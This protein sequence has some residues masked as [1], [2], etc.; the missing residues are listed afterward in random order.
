MAGK[1]ISNVSVA[2]MC[3]SILAQSGIPAGVDGEEATRRAAEFIL[4][5]RAAM[6]DF[7]RLPF[8]LM[9]ALFSAHALAREGGW[10]HNLAPERQARHLRRWR[11][12][13]LSYCRDFARF[14]ESLAIFSLYSSGC[15]SLAPEERAHDPE[16][17]PAHAPRD[18][19]A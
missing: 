18:A 12:S 10:F 8:R 7:L 15:G 13:R 11:R 14:H 1:L 19:G 6:P 16:P 2:A 4:R 5:E 9:T 3:R 17:R